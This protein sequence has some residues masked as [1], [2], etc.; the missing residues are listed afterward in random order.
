MARGPLGA[1]EGPPRHP[2]YVVQGSQVQRQFV[3]TLQINFVS[4]YC[5]FL[6]KLC[7]GISQERVEECCCK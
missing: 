2:Y 1:I 6:S 7:V 4:L 3:D 5:A